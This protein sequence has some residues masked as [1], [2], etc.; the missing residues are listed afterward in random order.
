MSLQYKGYFDFS[1]GYNDTTAQDLLKANELS[2]CENMD[3]L[4]MGEL[5][6]RKGV[7]KINVASKSHN[8]TKRFE[9]M[10]RDTSIILE[11]YNKNLYKIGVADTLLQALITDKPYFLQQQD[12]LYVCDGNE[13][14]EI[15]N[16]D[17]FSNIT[18][19]IVTDDIVQITDDFSV[20]ALRGKFYKAL[21]DLGSKDLTIEDYTVIANWEDVTDILSATSNVIR[22][23][24]TYAAGTKET[25]EMSIFGTATEAGYITVTLNGV[26]HDVALLKD[27]TARDVATQIAAMTIA[28]YTVTSKQNVVTFEATEIGYKENCIVE[29]YNTGLSLVANIDVNGED[30]DNILTEVKKCTKFIHHTKSGRYVATGNPNKPYAVYF[31]EPLQL[32][33]FK[34]FNILSPTSSEGSS[35]CL[36]NMLDSVL[37]GYR[38]S[39]FEYTGIDPATYG[40]WRR[41][42]I[43]YGCVAEYS[44][45]VLDF[46]NFV[47]LADNGLYLVS[48]NVLNQYSVVMQ[49]N[50]SVKSISDG[51]IENTIK[52]MKDKSKCVSIYYDGIYYLAFNDVVGDNNKIL[53]YYSDKKS[54]TLYSGIQANDLL[55]RK[56]GGLEIASKNYSLVFS[57]TLYSDFDVTTGLRKQIVMTIRTT[58]LTLDNHIAEKFFDKLF[59]QANVNATTEA[60]H[61]K[62][63]TRVDYIS[64]EAVEISELN[65]GLTWN[66][67]WGSPWGYYSSTMKNIFIRQKGSRIELTITNKDLAEAAG[68]NILFYGFAVSYKSLI[69]YQGFSNLEFSR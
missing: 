32:N 3:I 29:S 40:T 38:H 21:S 37:V 36:V 24:K 54:F 43:P 34:K 25:T 19:D 8:I 52:S 58:N 39:W 66:T 68:V 69:P 9:Y 64:S 33:Y 65:E 16:K 10:I 27:K 6:L 7:E 51:K 13:V 35:V 60:E 63:S 20:V 30:D 4:P 59:L 22:P 67:A 62:V 44:V 31:S 57:D 41:L 28:G 23:I 53:L 17:Y 18:V 50:S 12:V 56:N 26:A 5:K 42:A 47:F 55:Y 14:Y 2:A 61:F 48:A 45:Q 15:G 1:G 49:S 46:Y 11:V